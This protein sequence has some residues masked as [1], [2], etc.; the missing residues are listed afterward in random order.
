MATPVRQL[1]LNLWASFRR[2]FPT[3]TLECPVI[4][5]GCTPRGPPALMMHQIKDK[6]SSATHDEEN[7]DLVKFLRVCLTSRQE[8]APH[9]AFR[10]RLYSNSPLST[11]SDESSSL[12]VWNVKRGN[13]GQTTVPSPRALEWLAH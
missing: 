12:V 8:N 13:F 3:A 6:L 1:A 2:V 9:R 7:R 4:V 11:V 10:Q 5:A